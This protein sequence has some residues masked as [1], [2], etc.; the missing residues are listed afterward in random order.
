MI[1]YYSGCGNSRWVAK[2]LAA[3]MNQELR[4]IPEELGGSTTYK[5]AEAEPLGFVFP[6]Y[7]W[8]VPEVVCQFV[9]RMRLDVENNAKP[10]VFMACTCGDSIG[11]AD[12][13]FRRLLRRNGMALDAAISITMPE[14]YV[15]LPGFDVDEPAK[16]KQ[17]LALA[18][19]NMHSIAAFFQN[20]DDEENVVRGK[21]PWLTS[22]VVGWL[23]EKLLVTDKRFV[24]D[25]TC[26]SCGR[27]QE[28]CPLKNITLEPVATAGGK[29]LPMWHG[30]CISCMACYHYCPQNAIQWG[31]GTRGKGQYH[32]PQNKEKGE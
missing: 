17:K 13:R 3:R 10:Y 22:T 18:R 23:F 5:L 29:L 27:C 9:S 20:C 11:N 32:F 4:F 30:N 1:F 26:I 19:T 16:E 14:T 2:E 8:R 15:N 7:A 31:K 6:I 25:N 12:R 24:A 28:V 21:V